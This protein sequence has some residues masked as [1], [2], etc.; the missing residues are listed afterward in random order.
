M[1]KAIFFD[2]FF[3]LI[4]PKY[5]ETI[6]EYTIVKMTAAEW[7]V[8]AENNLLYTERAVGKVKSESD[9]ID[10]IVNIL[11]ISV[12]DTQKKQI[13]Q[14][15][16]NRMR[17]ALTNS[18]YEIINT[19][20]AIKE[21]NIKIGLIS[22]ADVIDCKYWSISKLAPYFDDVIFSCDVGFLKPDKEI[23]ELAMQRL[24]V[25]PNE[26]LFVG[27]GGSNELFG[28]KEVGM[29]TVFTEFLEKKTESQRENIIMYADYQII[30]F[31]QLLEII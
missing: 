30:D 22:N 11:P 12:S 24:N 6:N 10:R 18:S 19:L 4:I 28:A 17:N 29:R 23:Y 9:I 27:D 20:K 21:K 3:T 7:E 31:K 13:L 16:E 2:L 5:N 26:S 8:Y 14:A 25:M 15:R 1:I